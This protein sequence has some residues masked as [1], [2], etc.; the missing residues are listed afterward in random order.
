MKN[1]IS[2][3]LLVLIFSCE[4]PTPTANYVVSSDIE[5]FWNAYDQIVEVSD[6]TE[7]AQ[8]LKEHYIDKGSPGLHGMI[9]ARGY[10]IG[11]FVQVINDYPKFWKSVRPN[12]L[13]AGSLNAELNAGVE[14]LA[15]I[16]P[17]LKPAKI[18]FTIGA[19]RSNGTTIDSLVLIGSELAMSDKNT[20][21]SEFPIEYRE[22]RQT[23]FD[24]NPIDGIVLLNVH[25]YVHTQQ[26]PMVHNL[27]SQCIYEGVAEFVSVKAMGVPSNAPAIAF[28]KKNLEKVRDKFEKDM[29]TPNRLYHWLWGDADNGFGVR[30]LGYHV[31]YELCERYY[32]VAQD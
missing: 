12:T 5:L 21:A 8:L 11:D 18:Y 14:K 31:G 10:T 2:L 13:K 15:E 28:G 22:A 19:L 23:Y 25:E 20:D 3:L 30:D 32:D 26:K 7:Q 9:E 1:S 27:L 29:F 4:Q 24:S 6:S 17:D 16:Y